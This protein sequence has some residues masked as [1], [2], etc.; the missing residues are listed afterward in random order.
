MAEEVSTVIIKVADLECS[1][2]SKKIKKSLFKLQSH[3]SRSLSLIYIYIYI[4]THTYAWILF[5]SEH[6]KIQS[7][8]YEVKENTVIVSG[9]FNPDCLIKKLNL[10]PRLQGHRRSLRPTAAASSDPITTT[11]TTTSSSSSSFSSSSSS[12]SSPDEDGAPVPC[13]AG[14]LQPAVSLQRAPPGVLPVLHLRPGLR[15]PAATP[16]LLCSSSRLL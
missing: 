1:F 15:Q 8:V 12:S 7:T 9:L 5:I 6:L 13:L 3:L 4:Y 11:T 16:A 10:L 2:C 14:Q